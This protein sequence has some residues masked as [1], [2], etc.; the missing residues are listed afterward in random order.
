MG[1]TSV[2]G[3]G[4]WTSFN[5]QASLAFNKHI[6]AGFN[7]VS[8]FGISEL[9]IRSAGIVIPAGQSSIGFVYSNFGYTEFRRT[10]TGL[11][12]GLALSRDIAAGIQIDY[13]TEN[14][15]MDYPGRQSV[16][17]EAGLLVTTPGSTV[18][19][20]H[21]FNPVPNSL[22]KS[23]LPSTLTIGAGTE[24]GNS[25]LGAAEI[26]MDQRNRAL[27]RL[28]CEYNPKRQ[29]WL[30][31]GFSTGNTS[32][33]FGFGYHF[34]SIKLDLAFATHEKLGLTSSASII[35]STRR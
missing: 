2:T 8:R 28:G 19:G 25:L 35:F 31:T 6:S 27:L 10:M 3:K 7:H 16:T 5:N 1:S 30:R 32:F 12:C 18:V 29:L 26:E 11:A 9:G 21:V 33:S 34:R 4:F 13:L 20:I 14:P 22:R 17:F 24:L 15:S 23:N